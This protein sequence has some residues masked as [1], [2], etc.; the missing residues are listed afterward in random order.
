ML[1]G[2]SAGILTTLDALYDV[3]A[4][5]KL[6][7]EQFLKFVIDIAKYILFNTTKVTSIPESFE[8]NIKN[9]INF[10]NPIT[11]YNYVM[12]KFLELKNMLKV[13]VDVKSTVEVVCLQ[14]S[15]MQ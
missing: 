8:A 5:L 2:N 4:D 7:T 13:D 6:L 15:R 3:G 9:I 12:D 11:Y 14:I 1:D 10:E